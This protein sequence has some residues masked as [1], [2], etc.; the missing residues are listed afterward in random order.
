MVQEKEVD[1][2]LVMVDI[3]AT[4]VLIVMSVTLKKVAMNL[5]SFVKV[6]L[7]TFLYCLN[8]LKSEG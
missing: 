7:C 5:M 3:L 1:S 8:S 6:S 4:C 2:V